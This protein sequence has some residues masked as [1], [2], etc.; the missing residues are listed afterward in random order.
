MG[1]ARGS[2]HSMKHKTLNPDSKE[3]WN[4][5]WHEIGFYD[6]S[7]MIDFIIKQT[8]VLKVSFIGTSQ[9]TTSLM[10]LLSTRPEY[11]QKIHQVHLLIP[12][13]FMGFNT[14]P[15]IKNFGTATTVNLKI[16]SRD[17][18]KLNFECFFIFRTCT[19][20]DCKSSLH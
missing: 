16:H 15:L 18:I 12:V 13:V 9:G 8:N 1:N 5:S 20:M 2:K 6:L 11:N 4:F 7:A 3:F 17:E 10:V 14:C 19:I